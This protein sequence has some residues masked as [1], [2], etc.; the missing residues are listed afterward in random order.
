MVVALRENLVKLDWYCF[1]KN[2][3]VPVCRAVSSEEA[4]IEGQLHVF[5]NKVH[6]VSSHFSCYEVESNKFVN[7]SDYLGN[8]GSVCY[9]I[10]GNSYPVANLSLQLRWFLLEAISIGNIVAKCQISFDPVSSPS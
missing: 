7:V 6:E 10:V 5:Y 3:S 4:S 2:A 8:T 9:S 1:C